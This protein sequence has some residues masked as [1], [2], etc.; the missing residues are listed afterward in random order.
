MHDQKPKQSRKIH[1]TVRIHKTAPHAFGESARQS[2][3]YAPTPYVA[4]ICLIKLLVWLRMRQK[5][6]RL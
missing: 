1:K 3:R 5:Q 4:F 6:V 2:Q